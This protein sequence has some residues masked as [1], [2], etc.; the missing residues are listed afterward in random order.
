MKKIAFVFVAAI[1]ASVAV[2]FS[3][4]KKGEAQKDTVDTTA[5][6][7]V[8]EPACCENDTCGGDSCQKNDSVEAVEVAPEA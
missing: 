6:E 1:A 3:S 2:S 7:V 4:C 5:T 8:E